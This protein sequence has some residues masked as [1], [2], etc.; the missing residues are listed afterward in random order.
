MKVFKFKCY[1]RFLEELNRSVIAESR[2]EAE[3]HLKSNLTGGWYLY[4]EIE[5]DGEPIII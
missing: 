4:D 2:E 5:I 1:N 3:N